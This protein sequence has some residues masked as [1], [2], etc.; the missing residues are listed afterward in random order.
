MRNITMLHASH[1]HLGLP[2]LSLYYASSFKFYMTFNL[3]VSTHYYV[4]L[5]ERG[6]YKEF[7]PVATGGGGGNG[8]I[9]IRTKFHICACYR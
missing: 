3:L 8:V 4:Y 6:P 1:P 5:C 2:F 7:I 9:G